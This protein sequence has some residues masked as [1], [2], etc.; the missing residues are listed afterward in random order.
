MFPLLLQTIISNQMRLRRLRMPWSYREKL[1]TTSV[2]VPEYRADKQTHT[3]IVL[4]IYRFLLCWCILRLFRF[5]LLS[6]WVQ[7]FLCF[8]LPGACLGEG[9]TYMPVYT[10]AFSHCFRRVSDGDSVLHRS[11]QTKPDGRQ[12]V[13][14]P[15]RV[16]CQT[17]GVQHGH[18]RRGRMHPTGPDV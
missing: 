8:R 16:L 7:P 5:H 9:G 14:Q 17:D 15:C 6:H 10:Q 18:T 13:Q 11:D 4:C 1:E 2:P 3:Q 12:A